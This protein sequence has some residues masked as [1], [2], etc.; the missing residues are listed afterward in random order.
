MDGGCEVQCSINMLKHSGYKVTID[1]NYNARFARC[2]YRF[3]IHPEC[4]ACDGPR[5]NII[6]LDGSK[7][8][9]FS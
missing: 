7:T 2:S 9:A 1:T 8:C 4:T 5:K 6:T 3:F